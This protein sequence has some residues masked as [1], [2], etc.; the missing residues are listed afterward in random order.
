MQKV[1]LLRTTEQSGLLTFPKSLKQPGP[2]DSPLQCFIKRNRQTSTYHLY[3]GLSAALAGE[4]SKL[5]LTAKKIRRTTKTEF[6][7]SLIA[8]DFSQASDA[9]AGKLKSNFLGTKF[10]VY[11]SQPPC[12]PPVESDTC[13]YQKLKVYKKK[14]SPSA[15]GYGLIKISSWI[16]HIHIWIMIVLSDSGV[17]TPE[18]KFSPWRSFFLSDLQQHAATITTESALVIDKRSVVEE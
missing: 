13:L 18:R 8:N 6:I 9:F 12:V 15:D 2:R 7:I 4:A 16:L 3:L 5:L 1:H 10:M 14:V 17:P 11:N